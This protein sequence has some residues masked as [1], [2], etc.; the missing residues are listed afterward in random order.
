[1]A[2]T[3]L[4]DSFAPPGAVNVSSAALR[5]AHSFAELVKTTEPEVPQIVT[6][7]WADSRAIRVPKDGSWVEL[8]AGLDLAAYDLRD[9][10]KDMIHKVE[11]FDFAVKISRHIYEASSLR[12]IDADR[13]A[14]SGLTLR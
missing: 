11:G 2:Q 7:D 10:P 8:G 5:L 4:H 12:L 13:G 6:F 1:M 14:P 3:S 9:V